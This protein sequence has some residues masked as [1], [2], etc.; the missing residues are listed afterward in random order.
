MNEKK[1][2]YLYT[3]RMFFVWTLRTVAAFFV[4][5]KDKIQEDIIQIAH[6]G[7]L[8]LGILFVLLGTFSFA[9]EKYCDGNTSSYYTC[10]RPATYYYYPSWAIMLII[11][12]TFFIVLWF[13]RLKKR[14]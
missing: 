14:K 10:T 13:L 7:R 3:S 9:S 4:F 1:K 8:F 5:L 11:L 2:G 12:G 6:N